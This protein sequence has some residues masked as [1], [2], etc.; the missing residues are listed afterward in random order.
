MRS[1]FA[2]TM[3]EGGNEPPHAENNN[4]SHKV[5]SA[6]AGSKGVESHQL[7]N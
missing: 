4:S 2:K 7:V 1:R 6:I 3:G 5:K